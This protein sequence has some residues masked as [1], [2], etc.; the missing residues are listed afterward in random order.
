[1][2][3]E[4]AF[5]R[6]VADLSL[7]ERQELLRRITTLATVSDAPLFRSEELPPTVDL[8]RRYREA[9]F[10]LKIYLSFLSI[11]KGKDPRALFE[12]RL[13]ERI[14]GSIES[15]APGLYDRRRATLLEGF[16]AEL[17]ILKVSSRFFY[18]ALDGSVSRD[19]G[20]FFSFL[21]SLEFGDIHA[22]ILLE[23][24]PYAYGAVNS[25]A[26]DSDVRQVV[27]HALE[28]ILASID[29]EQ[30]RAMYRN[31]RSLQCLKD[32]SSFLF[33]RALSTFSFSPRDEGRI[34]PAYILQDQLRQLADILYSLDFPPSKPLLESLFV[35]DLQDRVGEAG[36]DLDEEAKA[37]MVKAE[38][39]LA[40]IRQFNRKVPL[41]AIVR[42]ASRDL[43]FVPKATTGGEDWFAV[44]RDYWRK[45]VEERYASF[46]RDRKR[47][48][49]SDALARYFKGKNT[50]VLTG[51]SYDEGD[52][53][54][55]L[56]TA[57]SLSFLSGFFRYVFLDEVNKPLKTILIDGE[58]YKKDNRLEF[59]DAY[60]ELLKLGD[61]ISA[62]ETRLSPNGEYG[63]SYAQ[64]R[65]EV[66]SISVKRRKL[67]TIADEADEDGRSIVLRAAKS[68]RSLSAVLGGAL[69]GEAG[70]R[71]DSLSNLGALGGFSKSGFMAGLRNSLQ[72]IDK[73]VQLLGEIES[74]EIGR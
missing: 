37:L 5:D 12:T 1:M 45:R 50:P 52:G 24:D 67:R 48:T 36:F 44:Y 29:E 56:R 16:A 47:E 25:Q 68:L 4:S 9:S 41:T 59:N 51:V 15:A 57:F 61:E 13:I 6:L 30:R 33:D 18:E 66:I 21:G 42:C 14:G 26:S 27:F 46:V 65:D 54:I 71:Y 23:A 70:G 58:F 53:G 34:C 64:A 17:E 74:V 63:K 62:L 69:N 49:L 7:E 11:F 40:T 35:F 32:L 73:A 31:V 8:E 55:P 22:K 28:E 20:A 38:E 10:L 2:E 19:K 43:A 60:N 72:K 39:S 3:T